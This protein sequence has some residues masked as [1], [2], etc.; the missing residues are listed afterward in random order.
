MKALPHKAL[1]WAVATAIAMPMPSVVM[2][3]GTTPT[4]TQG[5]APA[6]SATEV[7]LRQEELEQLLAPIALYP[8]SL[9]AQMLM[10]STYP[11]EIVLAARWLKANPK[12]TGK[13]L[14]DA[15]QKQRWDPSVK[16]LT[17]MPQVLEM[18]DTKIGWTRKVG[19]LSWPSGRRSCRPFR[20]CAPRRLPPAIS[21]RPPNSRYRPCRR[22]LSPSS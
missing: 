21:S 3:Q 16:S 13:A 15:M 19:E 17:A 4:A 2:A 5:A 14:E 7:P 6:Q 18:M 8:D 12:V 1:V 10:A 20:H 9:L 11:L 22:V